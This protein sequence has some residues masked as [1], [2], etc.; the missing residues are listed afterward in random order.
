MGKMLTVASL[1]L[2]LGVAMPAMAQT[3]ADHKPT[4]SVP[5]ATI[6]LYSVGGGLLGL[7]LASGILH[8]YYA[9]E[10]MF[11]GTP[12]VEAIEVGTGLPVLAAAAAVVVGGIYAHDIVKEAVASQ[13]T[14][15]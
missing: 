2:M 9:G 5:A 15:E 11:Q 12:F 10:M 14:E 3:K 7:G 8:L 1:V 13:S 4:E 6:D